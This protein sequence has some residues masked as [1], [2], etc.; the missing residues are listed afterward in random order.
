MESIEKIK[1]LANECLNCKTKP[2]SKACPFG[3]DIP[4]FINYIKENNLEAAYETLQETTVL[5]S[6][7][8]RICPHSKQCEGNCVR[9]IKNSPVQIGKL[10]AYVGDISIIN[11]FQTHN[12]INP[13]EYKV[14]IIG[15]GPAGITCA[16]TLASK[17]IDVTIFEQEKELGGLLI[18]GIPEFRLSRDIVEKVIERILKLGI[19]VKT[20]T[21]LGEDINLNNLMNQF[22]AIFL[23]FGANLSCKMNIPGEDLNGVFGANELLQYNKHPNYIGKKI[24][25]IGGGNV[26]L[27]AARTI[28][29]L[30]ADK[31]YVIYRRS[32]KQMPAE[33]KE[34]YDARNDG[35][36]FLFQTNIINISGDSLKNVSEIECVKTELIKVEN[37]EREIPVNIDNSNFKLKLDYVVTA[38]GSETERNLLNNLNIQT[39]NKGYITVNNN[40]MTSINGVFAGGDLSG[41]KSTVAWASRTG[42]DAAENIYKFLIT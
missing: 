25:I 32:E 18:H 36:E 35:V 31:V 39:N 20:S 40:Y 5:S 21:K 3:N 27:D 37:E 15:S 4:R 23:A 9:A 26:A 16:A 19:K 7:C 8:G 1:E 42:R 29:K 24:A 11:N 6:I 33:T 13:L 2:C 34:I 10:E 22:N 12:E 28:K 14:A 17:G 30:N 38:V 41:T